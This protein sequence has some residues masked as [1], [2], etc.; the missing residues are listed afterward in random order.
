MTYRLSVHKL[1]QSCLFDL[2]WGL[3]QRLTASLKFPQGL[4][5]LYDAWKR[6]YLGYY[7]QSLRGR[8]GVTG[9]VMSVDIDWH[10]Q[11]VQAEARLLSEFHTW[12]KH[13][14]LFDLRQ[15]LMTAAMPKAGQAAPAKTELFLTCAPIEIARLPWETW[16]VGQHMQIVRSP[17]H[18]RVAS[19]DRRSFRRGRARVLAILGDETGLNFAGEKAALNAQKKLL[20]IHYLGWQPGE[21]ATALKQ[22]ICQ[23][24]ADPVGWDVLFFAG[25]SNEAA[26]VGGQ[27]AIAPKTAI[28]IQELSPYLQ[29]A[30]QRSLQFAL[31]NSCSG[32]DIANGLINLGL[33]Q[34]AVMREPIHNEVAQTFLVQLMQRLARFE[35]VQEALAGA[36]RFLKVEQN[37]T[38]PSAYLV[39]SLFRHPDSVPYRI[40]PVGWRA[41]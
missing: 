18:I 40:Q 25:H 17:A 37:L 2:S 5:P 20:D 27:I 32:M 33:S 31:F 21:E 3:G 12:L 30:Q 38:Y 23:T 7:K 16:E 6:A 29:Q 10:S 36:C 34:V 9:Q 35:N 8:T 26:L 1:D 11:L 39:P 41:I 15:E 22:R 14:D 19:A 13:G 24:I 28:S 4:L